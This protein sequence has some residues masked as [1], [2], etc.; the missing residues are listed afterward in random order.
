MKQLSAEGKL[1][2]TQSLFMAA[3][4]PDE[5]LYDLTA[6]PHEVRNL[7]GSPAHAATLKKMREQLDAWL[8]EVD[9][10]G[11]YPEDAGA[12]AL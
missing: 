9:D 6:D 3:R 2:E 4:K 12:A 7:A 10:K 1:N 11:R 8:V 5:E